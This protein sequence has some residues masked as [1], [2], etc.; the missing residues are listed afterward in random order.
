MG[1]SL[2]N[3]DIRWVVEVSDL[4]LLATEVSLSHHK[5]VVSGD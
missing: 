5:L 4:R 1:S 3:M 2:M